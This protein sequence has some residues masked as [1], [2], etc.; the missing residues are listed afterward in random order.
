MDQPVVLQRAVRVML[1]G[2]SG[3]GRQGQAG[4][5]FLYIEYTPPR[6]GVVACQPTRRNCVSIFLTDINTT[7]FMGCLDPQISGACSRC[8]FRA[9]E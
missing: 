4:R 7:S 1:K 9:R 6:W 5:N 3:R 8:A 2:L